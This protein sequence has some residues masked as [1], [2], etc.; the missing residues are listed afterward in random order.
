LTT[1]GLKT[2]YEELK[3][4]PVEEKLRNT[5]QTGYNM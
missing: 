1:Q 4:E 3:V 2:I 5:N